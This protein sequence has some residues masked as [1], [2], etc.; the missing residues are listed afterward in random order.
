MTETFKEALMLSNKTYFLE[1]MSKQRAINKSLKK[2][3]EVNGNKVR[4]LENTISSLEG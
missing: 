3:L 4:V 1:A 2:N